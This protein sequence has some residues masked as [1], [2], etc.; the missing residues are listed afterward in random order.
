VNAARMIPVR[1][2]DRGVDRSYRIH[3]GRSILSSVGGLLASTGARRVM[4]VADAAVAQTHAATVAASLRDAGLVCTI[5][6]VASG[7]ASKSLQQAAELWTRFAAEAADRSTAVAAVGGGVIGDLAGFVAASFARGLPCW[8][9]PTTLVAQVDSAIGGKT[10]VNLEAGKN[11]VGAFWQPQGVVAD[12]D[13]LAT[14]PDREF[15]SGLAEVVKYGVILDADFF[16]WLEDQATTIVA[17]DPNSIATA[18]ERSAAHKAAV[19]EQDER[20]LTGLRAVLNYGHTFGHAYETATGYGSLL[21]GEAVALG[22]ASAAH[23][24]A[25]LGRIDAS[26][27]DRQ[28]RLL[29]ALGLP[30][31]TPLLNGIDNAQLRGIMGRDKK[32]LH[33]SLRFVLP[34]RLGA[35][36]LVPDIPPALVDAAIDAVRG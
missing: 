20:E 17:R 2:S 15:T 16:S 9:V 7:E 23:L 33:G 28:R 3:V 27:V 4:I 36:E 22:M 35:V 14:L 34:T 11:L 26:V 6:P 24:A 19:V 25:S 32:T 13:S 10:G 8:Q 12:I 29:Q 18:V 21:H 30:I 31:Q 1:L 5:I